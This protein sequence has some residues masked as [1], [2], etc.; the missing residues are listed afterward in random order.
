M[1][2]IPVLILAFNRSDHVRKAMGPVGEYKPERIYLACDGPRPNKE[3]EEM[4]VSETQ[5][6]MKDAVDWPCEVK[7]LF[8]EKNLGC[9][10]AVCEAITWFFEHEEYGIIIEDDVI[11]GRDFF[12]MCE[13]LLPR[14]AQE[15]RVMEISA[16]NHSLRA[17]INNSYVYSQYFQIWGW[18][19][20]RRAWKRMDMNMMAANEISLI[21]LIKRLGL[22]RG[23]MML[24]YFKSMQKKVPNLNTWDTA[25]YL[26]IIAHDGLVICP[27]INLAV[28][29]GTDGGTHYQKGD[30]DPYAHLSIGKIAWPLIYNDNISPDNAQTLYDNKDFLR[31]RLLGL[32]K[33]L[34]NGI[35][36]S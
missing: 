16:E 22:L 23:I 13:E 4:F 35:R 34:K 17:D 19:T 2:K 14:Y 7:T 26:S 9:A 3:G 27:G 18:A 8:R 29:I 10:Q 15:E 25:W 1:G 33:K 11:V 32:K 31:I 24:Y 28:N 30:K 21:Y 5:K 12:K 20:W 6:A 36:K